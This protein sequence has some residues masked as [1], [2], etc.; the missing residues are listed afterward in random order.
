MNTTQLEETVKCLIKSH[1]KSYI[2]K[3]FPCDVALLYVKNQ[4]FT[5]KQIHCVVVNLDDSNNP[6]SHWIALLFDLL[7]KSVELFDSL[8]L[9][10]V[11]PPKIASIINLCNQR[12]FQLTTNKCVRFQSLTTNCCGHYCA[13]F[14]YHR[15]ILGQNFQDFC[16]L[17]LSQYPSFCYRDCIVYDTV[18]KLAKCVNSYIK[19]NPTENCNCI[20]HCQ[21]YI[22]A[23]KH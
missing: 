19:D 23:N 10:C 15:L 7:H 11:Y 3:V 5:T 20:Q 9:H 16:H 8:G 2:V 22:I 18:Y 6:G 14:F 12:K 17:L 1:Y 13:L 21:S 4:L